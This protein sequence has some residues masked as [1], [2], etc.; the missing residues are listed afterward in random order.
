M[1][2]SVDRGRVLLAALL[3]LVL[4]GCSDGGGGEGGSVGG[5]GGS[6]G[7][8]GTGGAAGSGAMA[9]SGG[10]AGDGGAGGGEATCTVNDECAPSEYCAT[11]SCGGEG[12]CEPRPEMC[13]AL[14]APVCGCDFETY[15]NECLAAAAG[16]GVSSEGECPCFSNDDCAPSEYCA[17]M[18][19][20]E[21]AGECLERPIACP[22]VVDP[23]CGCDS[24]TYENDCFAANAGV[25]VSALGRCDCDDND[26]CESDS[27]CNAN[28]CDGP[29]VCEVKPLLENCPDERNPV[30]SCQGI[31][32]D[33]ECRAAAAGLRIRRP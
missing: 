18:Y 7:Q 12:V 32:F 19:A 26:D 14:L 28:T 6:G 23:V 15:D 29:G 33:N 5:S 24:V 30:S 2:F 27:F 8:A 22:R 3:V 4:A 21:G 9:G 13:N 20:C 1:T 11:S 31:G 25:R 17:A 10:S 16:Q